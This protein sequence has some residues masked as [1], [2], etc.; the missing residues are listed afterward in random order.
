MKYR[1]LKNGEKIK[2]GDQF[3]FCGIW[4]SSYNYKSGIVEKGFKY[5]RPVDV[6]IVPVYKD[7]VP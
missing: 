3:M 1:I 7:S 5:R 2:R 6:K 4:I